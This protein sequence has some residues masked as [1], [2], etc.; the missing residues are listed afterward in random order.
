MQN[1]LTTLQLL[2]Q[3]CMEHPAP[4]LLDSPNILSVALHLFPSS[5]LPEL[6]LQLLNLLPLGLMFLLCLPHFL[7]ISKGLWVPALLQ[8]LCEWTEGGKDSEGGR[9]KGI[10]VF[11]Q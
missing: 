1:H 4:C 9:Q 5:L 3:A 10:R 6:P 8:V 7:H 11:P 2:H